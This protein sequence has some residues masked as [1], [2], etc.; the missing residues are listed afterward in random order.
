MTAL[1]AQPIDRAMAPLRQFTASSASGGILLMAAAVIAIA[2]ANSPFWESYFTLWATPLTIG[3]G[4]VGLS[5]PLILWIN[6][7]LMAIFFLVVGLEIKREVLIG[8]LA[9]AR[10]AALPIAAAAGGAVLPAVLY[11]AFAAGAGGEAAR[12]WGIPMATDIAFALGVLALVGSRAPVA[13]KIFLTALAIV[14]DLIAVM[15]IALF[16]TEDLSIAALGAAA[17]VLV[18]LVAANRLGVRRPLVYAVLGVM[19]WVAVL[20][21]G[22]HAT[23][24]GV[25]LAMTIP[26][27][28]RI[29][30]HEFAEHARRLVDKVDH[31]ASEG[32]VRV[33]S[34]H[35]A[36]WELEDLTEHAQSPM[37]RMEHAL[38]PWV[39]YAIVPLF[40]LANA[41]VRIDR[42]LDA[43]ATEAIFLGVFVGLV[44]GKPVGITLATWLVVRSGFASLPAGVGWRHIY[45]VA[46]LGG[47]GFTMSLFIGDL[48]FTE[49]AS[50]AL[51]KMGILAASIVA[52]V[53]GFVL[54]R[55]TPPARGQGGSHAAH[56]E[57][58]TAT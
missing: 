57:R 19:L 23:I 48:A 52:G 51:A 11:L 38:H 46:W 5:K 36:L 3:L 10:R 20:Q 18:L 31:R 35:A 58:D 39:S 34:R 32:P 40:A 33:K 37:I 7:G 9:T 45:G 4:D 12:G 25:L 29:D 24:A 8:E 43:V 42:G 15:V 49:E 27:T 55:T 22:I 30:G 56:G 1:E 53:V 54:L 17:L 41:G 44:V 28:I 2:W 6:D 13:L 16:Y 21:S 50:L 26:A 47:I 14:D